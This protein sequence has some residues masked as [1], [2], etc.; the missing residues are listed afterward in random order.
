MWLVGE[1]EVT[2]FFDVHVVFQSDLLG[3]VVLID[4]LGSNVLRKE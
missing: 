3:C 1:D 4:D 2:V